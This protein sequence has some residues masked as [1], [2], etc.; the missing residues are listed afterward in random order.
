MVDDLRGHADSRISKTSLARRGRFANGHGSRLRPRCPAYRCLCGSGS[1]AG[2]HGASRSRQ[3]ASACA[4]GLG[5]HPLRRIGSHP[6]VPCSAPLRGAR[7]GSWRTAASALRRPVRPR[8]GR[9]GRHRGSLLRR[10]RN[11]R[12]RFLVRRPGSGRCGEL[13]DSRALVRRGADQLHSRPR[14]GHVPGAQF[15]GSRPRRLARRL[16]SLSAGARRR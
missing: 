6:W 14:G 5:L 16:Q 3:P 11:T 4:H 2:H 1:V 12:R 8:G 15:G 9:A 10:T 13:S 7:A